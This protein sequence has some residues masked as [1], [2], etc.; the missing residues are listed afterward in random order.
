MEF[1][2]KIPIFL[3]SEKFGLQYK[4]QKTKAYRGGNTM[5]VTFGSHITFLGAENDL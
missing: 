2:I 3:P 4:M 5:S 1:L